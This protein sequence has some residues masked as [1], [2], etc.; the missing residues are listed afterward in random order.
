M[1]L[2]NHSIRA[3]FSL[4]SAFFAM[5]G[6][7]YAP[8]RWSV[9]VRDGCVSARYLKYFNALKVTFVVHCEATEGV[10]SVQRRPG[11]CPWRS[12]SAHFPDSINPEDRSTVDWKNRPR[13]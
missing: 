5:M 10:Q 7:G 1:L 6:Q 9:V 12:V 13:H 4:F 8:E 3:Y 2:G 11:P